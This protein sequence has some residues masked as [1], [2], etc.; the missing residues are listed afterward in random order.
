MEMD[1]SSSLVE[2]FI[3]TQNFNIKE[4]KKAIATPAEVI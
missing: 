3:L 1:F 2:N 4:E